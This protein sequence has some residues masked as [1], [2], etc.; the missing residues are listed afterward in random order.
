MT[1]RPPSIIFDSYTVSGNGTACE[2][3]TPSVSHYCGSSAPPGGAVFA[4]TTLPHQPYADPRGA[5][6]TAMHGGSWCTFQYAVGDYAFVAGEGTFNFSGGGQQCGLPESSHGAVIIEGVLE[7]LDVPG[8][9]HFDVNTRVLTLWYNRSSGTPPP[10]D[11]SIVSPQLRQLVAAVGTQFAPVANLSFVRL[12]FRDT[13]PAAFAPHLAPS[14]SDYAV[15][16]EASLSL[17]GVAGATV[18]NC[19]FWRLDNSAI[20]LGGFTRDVA[21]KDSE[22]AWLGENGIVSVGDTEGGLGP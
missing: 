22:F 7:E 14:G 19:T 4:V 15:N 18:S 9:F 21:I 8:E 20:F 17:V 2:L 11:G 5:V 10:N 16:R 12:G 6:I 3:Y 13:P 1:M